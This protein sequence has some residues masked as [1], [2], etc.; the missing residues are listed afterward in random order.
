ML[1][2]RH[3]KH[4]GAMEGERALHKACILVSNIVL[5]AEPLDGAAVL[6]LVIQ[7]LNFEGCA[8]PKHMSWITRTW[9]FCNLT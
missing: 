8:P 7:S 5:Q 3:K 4:M 1:L 9:F 2:K 6:K